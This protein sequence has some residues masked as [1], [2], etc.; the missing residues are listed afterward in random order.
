MS[1]KVKYIPQGSLILLER[2][3]STEKKE[4]T[5]IKTTEKKEEYVVCKVLEVGEKV[6]GTYKKNS[7]VLVLNRN[8]ETWNNLSWCHSSAILMEIK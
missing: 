1:D 3:K 5:L 4:S 6:E 2:I 8:I 7:K